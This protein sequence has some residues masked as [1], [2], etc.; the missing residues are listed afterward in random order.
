MNFA[1]AGLGGLMEG[2]PWI[3]PERTQVPVAAG[4]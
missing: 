4:G 2:R 3:P 1:W